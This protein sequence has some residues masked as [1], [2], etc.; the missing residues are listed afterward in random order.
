M[1]KVD[2]QPVR[3]NN[4]AAYM[5]FIVFIISG[6]FFVLNLFIGVIIDNFNH[7]KQQMELSAK[8]KVE[9]PKNRYQAIVF[10]MV[11][12][13][14]FE[15]FISLVITINMIVMMRW[16]VFDFVIVILSIVG[17]I[18][19]NLNKTGIIITP[20]LL[21]VIRVF[22]VGRLLRFFEKAKGIQRLLFSL[23]IS[24]PALFNVGAILFLIVFIYA[25]IGM[26]FFAHVKKTGALNEVVN[27]E[28]F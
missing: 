12:N 10:D 4:M 20:N 13:R 17:I 15:I 23:V 21:R 25:I 16:N 18:V 28:T 6:S 11:E 2:Q 7:L 3:E 27:F 9:R 14:K 1:R 24:L 26:S 8:K 5:F 19:E 22:R